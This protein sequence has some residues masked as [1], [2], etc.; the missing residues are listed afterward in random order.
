MMRKAVYPGLIL[1]SAALALS[2]CTY[3]KD[4]AG[5]TKKPPDEFAVTTKAPL[6]VPPGFN[7]MPPSPGAAPTNALA[8]DAQAQAA[9]FGA[10]DTATIA[11]NIQGNYSPAERM[12]LATAGINRVDPGIRE[13]LQSD[14]AGMQGADPG[15]T[16]RLLGATPQP[17]TG[18]AINANAEVERRE[19]AARKP[20][21]A[22][23][24]SSGGWFDWF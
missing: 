20:A 12:L 2:G 1:C 23:K 4:A 13:Q 17:N 9:M 11:A 15:F 22:P 8:T 21:A 14:Q 24:T 3:L 7:L 19:G 5:M 6:I 10:G 18:Q 16:A